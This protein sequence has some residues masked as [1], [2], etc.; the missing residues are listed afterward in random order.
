ML[1]E[2][3]RKYGKEIREKYG[4]KTVKESNEKFMNLTPEEYKR[5][6]ELA[7]KINTMLEQA[8]R[9][10]ADPAGGNRQRNYCSA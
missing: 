6:Q 4:E 1:A 10:G 8:V 3:E 5:M 2:N 9:E 7:E